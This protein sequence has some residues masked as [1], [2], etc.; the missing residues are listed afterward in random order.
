MLL[1]ASANPI[2]SQSTEDALLW[3]LLLLVMVLLGGI[4][5]LAIRRRYQD[6]DH[7]ELTATFSLSSL[8]QMRDRGELTEEEFK[9]A[10]DH[11]HRDTLG[12]PPASAPAAKSTE[13]KKKSANGGD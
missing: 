8:R 9:R 12:A 4:V 7:D 2:Q 3:L 6:G 10:C 11:L 5:V 13:G 1:T